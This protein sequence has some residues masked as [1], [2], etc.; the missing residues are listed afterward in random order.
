MRIRIQEQ[1]YWTK[2][3]NNPNLFYDILPT[4]TIGTHSCKINLFVTA[5]SEKDPDPHRFGPLNPAPHW[6]KKLDPVPDPHWNQCGSTTLMQV[7]P[8]LVHIKQET[9]CAPR[10]QAPNMRAS[11][12]GIRLQIW[13]PRMR[14][15]KMSLIP[16][17]S[18]SSKRSLTDAIHRIRCYHSL[19]ARWKMILYMIHC[20]LGIFS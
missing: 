15:R 5:K 10:C 4:S 19:F 9:I 6:G 7:I 1:E 11:Y 12:A 2:L 13:G 17:W 3:T 14:I 18:G 8:I 16:G 20:E